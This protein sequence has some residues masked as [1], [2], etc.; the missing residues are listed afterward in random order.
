MICDISKEIPYLPFSAMEDIYSEDSDL[1]HVNI[2]VVN[3]QKVPQAPKLGPSNF[4]NSAYM[5]TD[6]DID[7]VQEE[8]YSKKVPNT[9]TQALNAFPGPSS[10]RASPNS[11]SIP[12][13]RAWSRTGSDTPRFSAPTLPIVLNRV[14]HGPNPNM[15]KT[16][17][18]RAP[19]SRALLA[20]NQ[21][22]NQ[23]G[24]QGNQNAN[25]G[26]AT[27][28]KNF[29]TPFLNKYRT[30]EDGVFTHTS[31]G[32]PMGS[33]NIPEGEMPQLWDLI[34]KNINHSIPTYLTEKP[35]NPCAIKIDLDFRFDYEE[36]NRLYTWDH[37]AGTINLYNEAIRYF[38]NT[39]SAHMCCMIFERN[40][41]YRKTVIS[42]TVS[43]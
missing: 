32:T 40:E 3:K 18:P 20:L 2:N 11:G 31:I 15:S 26:N 37:I 25:A 14:N 38:M 28:K 6:N 39:D 12:P 17:E 1:R 21:N 27:G 5:N 36:T 41:P 42:R 23:N 9:K 10:S 4:L 24:N 19:G 29:L 30:G 43:I 35:Q 13:T 16:T 33:Y 8:T 22:G 34:D 7:A